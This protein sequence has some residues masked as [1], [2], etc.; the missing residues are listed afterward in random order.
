MKIKP[1]NI[2]HCV[3]S[4]SIKWQR[5]LNGSDERNILKSCLHEEISNGL[6]QRKIYHCV[7]GE[8]K[9]KR[10]RTGPKTIKFSI[11][12]C[13]REMVDV[14]VDIGG[15]PKQKKMYPPPVLPPPTDLNM[16]Y[17]TKRKISI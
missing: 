7:N 17:S 14:Q 2:G 6:D 16:S 9:G 10:R 4:I 5:S 15:T 12:I 8:T 13:S 1:K 11:S 3:S